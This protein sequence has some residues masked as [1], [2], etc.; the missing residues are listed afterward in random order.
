MRFFSHLRLPRMGF[1]KLRWVMVAGVLV[2]IA[3]VP[4]YRQWRAQVPGQCGNS[5]VDAGEQCDIAPRQYAVGVQPI[6]VKAVDMNRDGILDLVT[7]DWGSVP[8]PNGNGSLSVFLGKGD[9]TFLSPI[10]TALN[11]RCSRAHIADFDV[12]SIPDVYVLCQTN[13]Y[14]FLLRGKGDGTFQVAVSAGIPSH[15][16]FSVGD[17]NRDGDPDVVTTGNGAVTV[18]LG[19]AGLTFQQSTAVS[20]DCG[21]STVVIADFDADGNP[22]VACDWTVSETT[23][24]HYLFGDGQG[25]FSTPVDFKISWSAYLHNMEVADVD[26]DGDDDL[27]LKYNGQGFEAVLSNPGRTFTEVINMSGPHDI[28]AA[29]RLV[30]ID[31]DG[32]L[33]L[34]GASTRGAFGYPTLYVYKGLGDGSFAHQSILTIN[35][36]ND[37]GYG[38]AVADL[39]N[40]GA[41]DFVVTHGAIGGLTGNFADKISVSLNQCANSAA[42]TVACQ[43]SG[44]NVVSS[45]SSSHSSSSLPAVCGNGTAEAGEQCGEP[46]LAS[47]TSGKTCQSC[48]CVSVAGSSS[49]SIVVTSSSSSVSQTV[50][51]NGIAET[52]E[53]CEVGVPCP[54]GWACDFLHCACLDQPMCGNGTADPVEQCGEPGLLCASGKTCSHCQCIAPLACIAVG[55][56]PKM[57]AVTPDGTKAYVVNYG[58]DSVS[59]ISTATNTISTSIAVGDGPT[60]ITITPDGTKAYVTNQ[61]SNTVS[62]IS[63]ASSTVAATVQVGTAPYAIAITPDGTKAYVINYVSNT[64]SVISTASSTVAATVQVGADPYA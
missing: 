27:F 35:F 59:V 54:F 40:S 56:D 39:D 28:T 57:I 26:R 20:M 7:T 55:R 3:A 43:C 31:G 14:V 45:S 50:C 8:F 2:A 29:Q 1:I 5:T 49:S 64:V 34:V 52:G 60:S 12:D 4:T 15:V 51:G 47:C 11:M 63:T 41:K 22:D 32:I 18:Y 46:G 25:G 30:D 61:G 48:Q 24:V 58:D 62:V 6:A 37:L 16:M 13:P 17:L 21:H 36:Q 33:D 10:T 44:G 23:M 42:C 38:L 53:E 19:G 9:G